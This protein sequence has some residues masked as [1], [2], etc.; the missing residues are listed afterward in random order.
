VTPATTNVFIVEASAAA[1]TTVQALL[2]QIGF[3]QIAIAFDANAALE[4]LRLNPPALVI[5]EWR[6]TGIS[7]LELLRRMREDPRLQSTRFL[8]TTASHHPQLAQT[9]HTLGA[10]GFLL[11]PF[12]AELLWIAIE[13]AFI[14]R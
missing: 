11:K 14:A 1:A 2:E 8:L 10:D 7:G 3:A 5:A 6:L 12:T 4:Q 13:Q 9:V